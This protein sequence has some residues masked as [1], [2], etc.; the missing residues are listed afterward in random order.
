MQLS[1]CWRA[2]FRPGCP[3]KQLRH[4]SKGKETNCVTWDT[5]GFPASVSFRPYPPLF[6][7]DTHRQAFYLEF[8]Y[9]HGAE[10]YWWL[11]RLQASCS[12]EVSGHYCRQGHLG[13][14]CGSRRWVRRPFPG[15]ELV[16]GTVITEHIV[17][18]RWQ[19]QLCVR[20]HCAL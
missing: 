12:L 20:L 6:S 16:T 1:Y 19:H 7:H 8:L 14:W 2:H 18:S 10:H 13:L 9:L 4:S 17:S 5:S 3:A 15:W 11:W